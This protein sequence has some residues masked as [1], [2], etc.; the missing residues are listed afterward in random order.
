MDD[1]FEGKCPLIFFYYLGITEISSQEFNLGVVD[2]LL[3]K[4]SDPSK[5][6]LKLMLK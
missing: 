3:I 4:W 1:L 2:Q 5:I 6:V